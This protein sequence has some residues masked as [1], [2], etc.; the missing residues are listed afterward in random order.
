MFQ[1]LEGVDRNLGG[2]FQV[3]RLLPHAERR[4][5]GPFVFLDHFGPLEITPAMNTDVRPHPHIG[6]A[7]V[8]FLLEGAMLH[9]DSLGYV[10]RIEPG[11]INLMKAGRGI[12]HSER[13][14]EDLRF[15]AYRAHGLQLWLGLPAALEESEPTFSHTPADALPA[16]RVQDAEIRL[17]IGA[18]LGRRSP[19]QTFSPTLYAA[20]TLPA[21][22]SL[23]LPALAEELGVYMIDGDVQL[24][25]VPL[26]PRQLAVADGSPSARLSAGAAGA[27]LALIGGTRLDG[28]RHLSWNF[29]SSRPERLRQ[30]A[31]DWDAQRFGAVPGE[32]E[33]IPL[34]EAL[35]QRA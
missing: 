18:A 7:T 15:S 3:R 34:P 27:R 1:R 17:L 10:Q 6:L 11:A 19:V 28:P 16:F 12:V 32:T 30:A 2:G 9:R 33:F 13:R 23:E 26:P 29:V 35:R 14:P 22:G 25:D 5:V 24:D 4:T 31:A 8:T 20:L 21:G